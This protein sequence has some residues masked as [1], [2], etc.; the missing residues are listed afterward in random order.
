LKY[1]NENLY[2]VRGAAKSGLAQY[3]DAIKDFD[4]VINKDHKN[5]FAYM[6]RAETWVAMEKKDS[7]IADLNFVLKH[8]SLNTDAL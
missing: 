8:D 5:I 4:R 1:N 7:A 2:T 3:P 6:Q